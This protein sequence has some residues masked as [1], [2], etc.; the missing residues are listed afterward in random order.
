MNKVQI[1]LLKSMF[2]SLLLH[3]Q[4]MQEGN[5][6]FMYTCILQNEFYLNILLV[7]FHIF[8]NLS[9]YVCD[10]KRP[11]FLI[12]SFFQATM[13]ACLEPYATLQLQII[14]CIREET[15][16]EFAD[17]AGLKVSLNLK[18]R[19]VLF[20]YSFYSKTN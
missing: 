6:L 13:T 15:S 19:V 16:R 1:N 14:L 18:S 4:H 20:R 9:L 8:R 11:H 17:R 12:I 2:C 10:T 7:T 3:L 5:T